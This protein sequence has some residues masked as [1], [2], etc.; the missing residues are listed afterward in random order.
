MAYVVVLALTLLLSMGRS[1]YAQDVR[2]QIQ[3][4]GVLQ[5][6]TRILNCA[7]GIECSVSGGIGILG[8]T[9]ESPPVNA[10][11]RS[12]ANVTVT[13]T[14]DETTLYTFALEGGSLG[15]SFCVTQRVVGTITGDNTGELTL[16]AKYGAG[17]ATIATVPAAITDEALV[18]ETTL[19]GDAATDAQ[20]LDFHV[21]TG[22][23]TVVSQG[24]A[25]L[26]IDSTAAANFLLSAQWDTADVGLSVSKLYGVTQTSNTASATA[27][28]AN[29][30]NCSAGSFPLGVNAAGVAESCTD[31][32][33]QAEAATFNAPTA[34]ALAANGANCSAGSFPLGVNASGAAESC[35]D[36]L[37]QA[38][39]DVLVPATATALA[40]NPTDC[41]S[42]QFATTIAANGNLTCAALLDADVP[43]DITV[44]VA[45]LATTASA[46][47]ANPTDCAANQF[48]NT[49]AANGNLTCAAIADADVPDD[50]TIDLAT[51]ATA[52]AANGANC[53]AGSAPLGVDASGAAESC[54]A[55][56]PLDATLTT[57]ADKD[58]QGDGDDIRLSSG[59]FAEGEC[60]EVDAA[61][62][63]VSAGAACGTGEGGGGGGDVS[64]NTSSSVDSEIAL[65]S[66]TGGKTIKRAT[67]SG[68]LKG[69]SGVIGAATQDDISSPSYC[70]DAGSTDDYTCTLSPAI[71]SYVTGSHYWFKANTLNTGASTLALNGLS[72]KTIKKLAGAITTDLA[73]NDIRAG[74]IVHVIYDGTNMQMLSQTGN[75]PG[76][77]APVASA[78]CANQV[79]ETLQT[80][81]QDGS[82]PLYYF[83]SL[84]AGCL[85]G[86]AVGLP[87]I[88]TDTVGAETLQEAWEGGKRIIGIDSLENGLQLCVDLTEPADGDCEDAEDQSITFY[89]DGSSGCQ[90][91]IKPDGDMNNR[92]PT[93]F[94]INWQI[95]NTTHVRL[96]H[97]TGKVLYLNTG[98]PLKSVEVQGLEFGACTYSEEAVDTNKPKV[99]VFTCTDADT[100]GF[101]FNF[102]TPLNWDAGTVTVRLSAYHTNSSPSGNLVLSCSGRAVSDGNLIQNRSTTGEQT[103]TLAMGTDNQEEQATSAAITIND[104]P[105]A[106]DRLYMHCDV[107]ATGTTVNSI[108]GVRIL[109][110]AK[111]FF[112]V[113]GE[114]E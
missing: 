31:A 110:T 16:R 62:N 50:V 87:P 103:V 83:C 63:F 3:E 80:C 21:L 105:V 25:A 33:T 10:L 13:D 46:L 95:G 92:A 34:T 6:A 42:N 77:I 2:I 29:G 84:P 59:A 90:T 20:L 4:D 70:A 28:A 71:S 69:T 74:Q 114:S 93:G 53:S 51:T 36:A 66:S 88:D 79:L 47:A 55:V 112:T 30:A 14:T 15:T 49:I 56:Q 23:G 38:E 109:S 35:T 54:F 99:G 65:F 76:G 104:T 89:C 32:L 101:D 61:G 57:L 1:V 17:V 43:D 100:D 58:V 68:I 9:L 102:L 72:S 24:R 73:D 107:D 12:T 48:A 64:S 111:V 113:T 108:S 39:A 37:T 7:D 52:L 106:G 97:T 86:Q 96:D 41:S 45:T 5:G 98:Q 67:T 75:I 40:A 22:S 8:G 18:V 44:D 19:C 26:A 27:L 78:D 85:A 60:V 11:D 82:P 91:I 81:I 94:D